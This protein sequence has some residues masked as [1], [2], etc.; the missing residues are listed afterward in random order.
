MVL[1]ALYMYIVVIYTTC[2]VKCLLQVHLW[3]ILSS[4]CYF[5]KTIS[6]NRKVKGA[7]CDCDR[8]SAEACDSVL[9]TRTDTAQLSL[10]L[11]DRN[12]KAVSF[13]I[14]CKF[15]GKGHFYVIWSLIP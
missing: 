10:R 12:G 6:N 2:I 9:C 3:Y 7:Q 8:W 1:D 5:S 15:G 4:V 13:V 11:E 14:R